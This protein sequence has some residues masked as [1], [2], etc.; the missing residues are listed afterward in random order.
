MDLSSPGTRRRDAWGDLEHISGVG[1]PARATLTPSEVENTSGTW[2]LLQESSRL[3]ALPEGGMIIL[4]LQLLR[5]S[6]S[7]SRS[8]ENNEGSFVFPWGLLQASPQPFSGKA[9]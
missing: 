5:H 6:E 8:G 9:L 1:S 3:T 2:H 4:K 7:G